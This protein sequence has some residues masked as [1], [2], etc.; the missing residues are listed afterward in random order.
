MCVATKDAIK[1]FASHFTPPGLSAGG[2]VAISSLTGGADA[3]AALSLAEN[4][5]R[6]VLAVTPG[7]PDADRLA[8]D[9]RLLSA[10]VL[11]FPP[12]LDGDR[13]AL[14]AR[15]KTIAALR[16]WSMRPYPC[17]VVAAY[18]ALAT[19][20]PAEG[21][22]PLALGIG[23]IK[24][25][26][27]AHKLS[28]MG[29]NRVV[30]VEQEGDY[31]V[32]GGIID[33]WSPGEEFPVYQIVRR[34]DANLN[35]PAGHSDFTAHQGARWRAGGKDGNPSRH[36]AGIICHN[37]AGAQRIQSWRD[38]IPY[39]VLWRSGAAWRSGIRF[40]DGAS[41]GFCR[42]WRRRGPPSG[43]VRRR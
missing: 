14:G 12:P 31:S 26:D 42:A 15:L 10:S 2:A 9:L 23:T 22:R 3:F 37:R 28:E 13:T 29:Y 17:I 39:G 30:T 8:D 25:E 21:T 16:A 27:V 18:P 4:G 43:T 24:L 34:S 1:L 19:P 33:A 32:R 38:Q 36:P 11:E 41:A 7:L 35:I 40:S 6:V 5:T 20:I